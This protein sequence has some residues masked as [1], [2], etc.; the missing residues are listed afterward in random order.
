MRFKNI[1]LTILDKYIL[2]QILEVF[3]LGIIVFTAILFASDAFTSLIKQISKF[4]MPMN[5]AGMIIF[6]NLPAVI[7]MT[8]PMSVL[9]STV[10]TINKLCLQSEI[11]VMKACGI[12]I[13]RIAKPI[14]YFAFVMALITFFINEAIV[15]ATTAQS[16]TLALYSLVQKNIPDGKRNFTIKELKNG[17][18]LRRLFYVEKCEDKEFFNASIVDLSAE[19]KIQILQAKTGTSVLEGW[20]FNNA[21]I[22][23]ISKEDKSL[24]T[25]WVEKTVLDFG[26]DIQQQLDKKNDGSD[27]N[28]FELAKLVND[29]Q[30]SVDN[31]IITR[32]KVKFWDKIALPI[33]TF[34]FVLLGVP[35]AITPPRV[36]YNRG[37]LFCIAVIF[38]YYIIRAFSISLGFNESIPAFL[39][40]NLP[41]IILGLLGY[42][43][44]KQKAENI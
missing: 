43:L 5:I 15:P 31:K 4:G 11:T 28:L 1:K 39:A 14:F 22:Y 2:K 34:V 26:A 42:K 8:I 38:L 13:K 29:K 37:L 20:Q 41:N 32:Y 36:R 17:N 25:S 10:M 16:K 35:L 27:Y 30:L 19:D 33:T 7:V 44:Y 9:F 12:G 3:V 21:S 6:L 40:A 24:N 23:T 18:Y